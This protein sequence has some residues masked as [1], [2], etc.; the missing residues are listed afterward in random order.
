MTARFLAM[1]AMCAVFSAS[2]DAQELATDLNQ[3]RVLV[4]LGDSLTI[5]D[6]A[7]QR[8]QG[9]LVQLDASAIVLELP[10]KQ[11]RQFDDSSVATI[12]KGTDDR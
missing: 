1:A 2:A 10:N 5:I 7:G 9:R 6:P 4:K 8:A 11:K 3:L 12:E